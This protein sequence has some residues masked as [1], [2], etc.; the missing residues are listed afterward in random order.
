MR[1]VQPDERISLLTSAPYVC[2]HLLPLAAFATGTHAR[3][4]IV[5]AVLYL[6]RGFGLTAGYHRYFAHRSFKTSRAMQF[7]LALL[8][9]SALQK[10]P[11][12][13]A[14][15]HRAHHEYSDTA[16]DL[17]SPSRS[18][19][20]WSH[21]G[22]FLCPKYARTPLERIRDFARYPELMWLDRHWRLPGGLLAGAL[23]WYG[24]WSMFLIGFCLSTVC[25]YHATYLVNSLTHLRGTRRFP[26]SD[27]SRNNWLVALVTLGEGWHNNHHF[28]MASANQGF[29]WWEFDPTYYALKVLL[30]TR[31]VRDVRTPPERILRAGRA[32]SAVVVKAAPSGT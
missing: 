7:A 20:W 32:P 17:H 23:L 14:G 4:W 31:L 3:D 16:K 29:Y 10:G 26:T 21:V 22:W 5:C 13:W 25:S 8:G 15:Q 19:F 24:G 28:Y 18:G 9:T 30:W 12:W 27:D 6:V 2:L 11:L 1:Q